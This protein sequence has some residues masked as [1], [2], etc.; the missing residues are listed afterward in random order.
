MRIIKIHI[1]YRR[2]QSSNSW[3]TAILNFSSVYVLSRTPHT[4]NMQKSWFVYLG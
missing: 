1:Q 2:I 3:E 4:G